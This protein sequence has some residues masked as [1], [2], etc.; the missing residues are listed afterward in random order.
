MSFTL[1]LNGGVSF[2]GLGGS[3]FAP[4]SFDDAEESRPTAA[5]F[6]IGGHSLSSPYTSAVQA[7]LSK[8]TAEIRGRTDMQLQLGIGGWKK[9]LRE[10]LT[11]KHEKL[12]GW[13]GSS[14]PSH[15]A[16]GP[17]EVL[18]RRFTNPAVI[19]S[20]QSHPSV[21][22]LV[23]DVSGEDVMA[24]I[25]AALTTLRDA[26]PTD[27]VQAYAAQTRLLFEEYRIAGEA[28]G[29]AQDALLLKL[30]HL[31]RVQGKLAHLFDIEPTERWEPLMEATEAYLSS[32]YERHAFEAEYKTLIA[33]YRRFAVLR[34]LFLMTRMVDAHDREPTCSICLTEK[35]GY[36][37]TPCGH[38]FC[39]TCV[40]RQGSSC[41]YCRS[42]I[43]E[44]VKL[45]F[46]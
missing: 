45:Y 13:L 9:R 25:G 1:S 15:H 8:H 5:M 36:C 41:P 21:R 14:V 38:T 2:T 46:G 43:K 30:D 17:G 4:A 6:D 22:D 35:V 29:A 28:V 10:F 42:Q 33:A 44:R 27:G 11:R 7:M 24:D 37:L 18:L 3:E 26:S 32:L 20:P 23:L 31:D 19:A 12:L 34:E 16:L 39:G 40:R